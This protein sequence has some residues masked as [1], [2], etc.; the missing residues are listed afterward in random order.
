MSISVYNLKLTS[1]SIYGLI[2]NGTALSP[3]KS[4]FSLSLSAASVV[5]APLLFSSSL[6]YPTL[7]LF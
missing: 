7:F 1:L 3:N 2:S 5:V 4:S 6:N